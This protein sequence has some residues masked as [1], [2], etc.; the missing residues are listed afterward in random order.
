MHAG[1]RAGPGRYVGV[2]RPGRY[3]GVLQSVMKVFPARQRPCCLPLCRTAGFI[4]DQM[5]QQL[6]AGCFFSL[7]RLQTKG[8]FHHKLVTKGASANTPHPLRRLIVLA[9]SSRAPSAVKEGA[10]G[11]FPTRCDAARPPQTSRIKSGSLAT[12]SPR[13]TV[14][15][16]S[17]SVMV[18]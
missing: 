8:A 10:R 3:V 18:C 7:N 12:Q 2:L 5:R 11:V 4:C 17:L 9:H 16:K 15:P 1:V 14:P 13:N 6:H